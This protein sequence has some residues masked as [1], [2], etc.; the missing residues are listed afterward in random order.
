MADVKLKWYGDKE[1]KDMNNAM[2]KTLIRGTN[3]VQ[4]EA[5]TI[6]PVKDGILRG[7]IVKAVDS[8]K[9][10]GTVSTNTEYAGYVEFGTRYQKAQ[11]YMRPALIKSVPKIIRIAKQEGGKSVGS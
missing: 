1:K 11:P 9:L 4:A 7:S 5:K 10:N 3:I 6:V 8:S 2:I